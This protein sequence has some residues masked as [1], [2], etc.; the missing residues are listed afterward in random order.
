ML[1]FGS[2]TCFKKRVPATVS[3]V[4]RLFRAQGVLLVLI[5]LMFLIFFAQA[6]GG[7]WYFPL[8]VVPGEIFESWQQI[9]TGHGNV[10]NW[11]RL[12]TLLSYAFLHGSFEHVAFNMIFLW[13]FAALFVELLG[14]RWMLLMFAVTAVG[15][16]IAHSL[17][18]RG[19]FVPM[20]GASGA[21]MGFEGAYLGLAVR[22]RLPDP[23]IW[24]LARP[25]P[26]AHLALMAVIG[27]S[28]DYFAIAGSG[29]GC[30]IAYGAHVGGFTVGLLFAALATP[31]PRSC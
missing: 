21:V 17:M 5:G 31:R 2:G 25:I 16:A 24:P 27:V 30:N 23:H 8:M 3:N 26:P 4:R 28:I 1:Q 15:A 12:G 10:A 13:I 11:R 20:L 7:V 14:W 6:V 18:N 29:Q 22:W 19:E 9:R